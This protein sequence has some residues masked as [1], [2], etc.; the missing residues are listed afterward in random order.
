MGDDATLRGVEFVGAPRGIAEIRAEKLEQV[1]QGCGGGSAGE[2][3]RVFVGVEG[4]G[5]VAF[6]DETLELMTWMTTDA[7]V[8]DVSA[9]EKGEAGQMFGLAETA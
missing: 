8:V 6:V 3:E 5:E 9:S 4:Q 1:G 7:G 2:D